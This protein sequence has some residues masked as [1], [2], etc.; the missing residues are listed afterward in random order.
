MFFYIK[1]RYKENFFLFLIILLSVILKLKAAF[2]IAGAFNS[3]I[4]GNSK[5]FIFNIILCGVLYFIYTIILTFQSWYT[6]YVKQKMLSDIR[7]N[8]TEAYAKHRPNDNPDYTDGKL[9]SWLTTDINRIDSEGYQS[10]YTVV[11]AVLDITFS[12]IAL[13]FVNWLLLLAIIV[14]AILNLVL[15]KLVDGKM[16]KAFTNLTLQ[17]ESFTANISNLFEG[18]SHLF[19]LNKQSF[20]LSKS[21]KEIKTVSETEVSTYKVVGVA[22]FLAALGNVLGQIGLLII[23]GFFIFQKWLSFGDVLSVSTISA[24]VFNGVSNLTANII[25]FK[26]V[27]PIFEKHKEFFKQIQEENSQEEKKEG[28]LNFNSQLTLNNV[29][30][31]LDK[32]TILSNVSYHFEKGK[33]YC[34]VGPSG[35]GK[36][37]LFK[38]LNGSLSCDSGTIEI[39]CHSLETIKGSALRSQVTYVEQ[40]PYIFNGTIRENLLLDNQ[41]SDKDISKVIAKVGLE[42]EIEAFPKGLD[43]KIG[44]EEINLSGGQKQR[45]ALARALLNGSRFLLLDESTS[46]LNKQ[47]AHTIEKELLSD[48][49]YSI[50][51][52]T[53]HLSEDMIPYFD[54]IL[55]LKEGKLTSQKNIA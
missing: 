33:K 46:S 43:T 29:S 13:F 30:L 53:H 25:A 5:S 1:K 4:S 8:I 7:H 55:E 19:S 20:L 9:V 44:D 50:I 47:L 51:S 32:H 23:S 42:K 14:L 26:G 10:F 54:D 28:N 45:L 48:N 6:V 2:L 34:I 24:N 38:V 39:D 3:L 17:Q 11:E 35:A 15:P 18:F 31:T 41:F 16:A 36:S 49:S 21:D 37:T 12:I 22:T 27:L 52:I 40:F